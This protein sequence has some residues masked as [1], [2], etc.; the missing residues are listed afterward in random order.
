MEALLILAVIAVVALV[1]GV[2]E[3]FDVDARHQGTNFSNN[4]GVR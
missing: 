3:I 1:G 2:A 4:P